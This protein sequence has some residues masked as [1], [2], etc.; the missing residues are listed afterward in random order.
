MTATRSA[1]SKATVTKPRLLGTATLLLAAAIAIEITGLRALD[2]AAA[3]AAADPTV[4]ASVDGIAVAAPVATRLRK[5]APVEVRVIAQADLP[6][7]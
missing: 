6:A 5:P 1:K 7:H 4:V 3:A 2:P